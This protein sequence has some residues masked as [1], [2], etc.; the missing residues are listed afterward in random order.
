MNGYEN[1]D[2][3]L[4][5][6]R[7][8]GQKLYLH[9]KVVCSADV[10]SDSKAYEKTIAILGY[11]CDEG[12][13]RN[14]GRIGA[15]EG[16]NAIR[17]QLGKMPDHLDLETKF[18]DVGSIQCLDGDME[19]AQNHLSEKVFLLLEN[20]IFPILLGGGHDIAYGHYKGIK[21]Y[22]GKDKSVGI[23]NFDAHFDLRNNEKGNNSGTPFYQIAQDHRSEGSSFEYLCMGI[24]SDANDKLLFQTAELF[25][26]NY[27]ENSKFVMTYAQDVVKKILD[28]IR[29]E[30]SI[31]FM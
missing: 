31:M 7:S 6:G 12:V 13:R 17:K 4:W 5:S 21:Q 10:E 24:R 2:V 8:S 11:A 9:E 29:K 23:I 26:V 1:P 16:P 3:G 27:I 20:N 25:D 19:A 18:L 28:F 14:Q 30:K 15:V 22:L